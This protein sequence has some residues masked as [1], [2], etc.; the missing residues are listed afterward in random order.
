M[1]KGAYWKV[2]KTNPNGANGTTSDPREKIMW[3]FYVEGLAKGNENAY[4]AA[5]KAGYK[6]L[7][8]KKITVRDWFLERK[9]KLRRKEMLEKAERNLD[10]VLD[11]V[12]EEDG[13]I[14]PQLLRIKT[15]VSTTVAKTLGKEAYSE[16]SELTGKD[17]KDLLPKPILAYVQS[18]PGNTEGNGSE[19][20][21]PVHTGGDISE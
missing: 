16:R 14:N 9:S 15:D 8:A 6:E 11:L 13:K 19:E 12:V 4:E 10:K 2:M 21:T 7:S 17:G 18:D 3:D 1:G 20:E 5:I